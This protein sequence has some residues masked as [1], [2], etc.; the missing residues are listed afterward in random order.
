MASTRLEGIAEGERS[1]R[2][3]P[4][5]TAPRDCKPFAV[6]PSALHQVAG[7]V[8]AVVDID[9]SPLT[10][11]PPAVLSTIACTAPIIHIKQSESAT[12]PI[13]N[14][15][16]EDIVSSPCW[17][18]MTMHDERRTFIGWSNIIAVLWRV[19]EGISSKT[20]FSRELERLWYRE[21]ARIESNRAGAPQRLRA[22][23]VQIKL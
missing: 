5:R 8:H 14:A 10:F 21:I 17:P 18:A 7:A 19:V 23:R 12:G 3:V 9:D 15:H 11:K 6:H 1:E 13:L 20:L 4:A 22:S 16:L 2:R